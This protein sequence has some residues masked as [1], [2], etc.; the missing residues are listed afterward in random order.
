M[1]DTV[2]H[3]R[4]VSIE[5]FCNN[6]RVRDAHH[7]GAR[8][9]IEVCVNGKFYS[10]GYASGVDYNC[11][12]DTLRQQLGLVSNIQAVRRE[13]ERKY[14]HGPA[15]IKPGDFLELEY[16]WADVVDLLFR[17]DESGK[18]KISASTCRII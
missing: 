1:G 9:T 2:P 7:V 17:F 3:M 11:L 16:H 13:L 8:G 10:L 15:R 18:P 12:I 5:V 4:E 14:R 6:E